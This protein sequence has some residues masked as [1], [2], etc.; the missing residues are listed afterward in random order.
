MALDLE[1]PLVE[2]AEDSVS[3]EGHESSPEGVG[4]CVAPGGTCSVAGGT[5][6]ADRP[7]LIGLACTPVAGLL[8]A[9][10][11]KLLA[12]CQ[13]GDIC[14]KLSAGSARICE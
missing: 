3:A 2:T 4:C 5:V 12:N 13:N 14:S 6:P 7:F 11:A 1:V 9:S 8:L 10:V